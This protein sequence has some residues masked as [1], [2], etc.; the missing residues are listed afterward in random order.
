[1]K[2]KNRIRRIALREDNLIFPIS[3][4]GFSL[5]SLREKVRT[6][7]PLV[8]SFSNCGATAARWYYDTYMTLVSPDKNWVKR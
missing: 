8:L 1:M 4:Y 3:G 5:P 6:S 7:N 2:V